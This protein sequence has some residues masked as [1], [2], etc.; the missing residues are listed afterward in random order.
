[1]LPMRNTVVLNVVVVVVVVVGAQVRRGE[2]RDG[3]AQKRTDH[4]KT[5]QHVP[6]DEAEIALQARPREYPA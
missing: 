3:N 4:A 5:S 1:M 2:C 6:K